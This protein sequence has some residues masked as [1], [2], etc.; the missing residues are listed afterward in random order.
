MNRV[1]G[2]LDIET[3]GFSPTSAEL[4]VIG[5]SIVHKGKTSFFQ[6]YG[7]QITPRSLRKALSDIDI[8]YTYN[9]KKFDLP[10]IEAKT[11]VIVDKK[12]RHEDLMYAC[13]KRGLYGGLKAVERLLQIPRNS[14]DVD[15]WMAVQLWHNFSVRGDKAS[16]QRLLD[17]NREDVFN[18]SH[19]RSKLLSREN[20]AF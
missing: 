5:L 6:P 20:Y 4:T 1:H 11:G 17:Y 13:W 7:S 12:C 14:S 10:F 2:Y 19:L 16:L 3:T 18:L 9:G 15:G 8:L